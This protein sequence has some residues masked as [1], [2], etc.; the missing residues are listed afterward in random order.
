[1]GAHLAKKLERKEDDLE[2]VRKRVSQRA[3]TTSVTG[4]YHKLP[5]RITDKY[6]VQGDKLGSGYNGDVITARHLINGKLY[7]VKAFKLHGVSW[8]KREELRDETEIFLG[9]DHPHVVRLTDVYESED[10]LDLVMECM[11][12]GELYERVI[13]RRK[14]SEVDAAIATKQM[15]LA[16]NY[17]HHHG[18]V[19]RDLKLE[20][21]LYE[22]KETNH[23]KLIDFGF[24][25][26]WEPSTKMKLSCGTLAYVAPEVLSKSY[27]SKC[28]LWSLGVITFILLVGYMP[29]S[30]SEQKQ[31]SLIRSGEYTMKKQ[32]WSKVSATGHDFVRKL[33][34][35]DVEARFSAAQALEHPW[36]A[37]E[38]SEAVV[39]D[40]ITESLINFAQ[41]SK[42]RR[43]CMSVMAWS[44]TTEERAQVR[45][46]FMELDSSQTGAIKLADFKKVLETRCSDKQSAAIFGAL[47][48]SHDDEIHY[49]EFLAAMMSSRFQ[50]HDN[51][52]KATFRRFDADSSGYITADNL[53]TVLGEGVSD[54]DVNLI[55]AQ[56]DTSKDGLISYEEFI[57]YLKNS[58]EDDHHIEIAS[59]VLDQ[60]KANRDGRDLI[61]L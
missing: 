43:A 33:L 6:D 42:F 48:V 32:P 39:D 56:L 1:M 28:D 27:T 13:E 17:L 52:L 47:D 24:S 57:A 8:E 26:L 22:K 9:L 36:I 10:R 23:L 4:R 37:S 51:L 14:F 7:A 25:K 21:F 34:V 38:A 3:G 58:P 54:A 50:L 12:G 30:G 35:V 44:L 60:Q 19:H 53:R 46:A 61:Y 59:K 5:K 18:V 45:D 55:V 2:A 16:V 41:A 20:N 29:F 40:S 15:L 49:S 11:E 31:M